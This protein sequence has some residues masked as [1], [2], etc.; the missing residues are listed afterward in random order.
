[1]TP[2]PYPTPLA[3]LQPM[4]NPC[5]VCRHGTGPS[6]ARQC[7]CPAVAGGRRA[8]LAADARLHGGACGPEALHL[9]FPED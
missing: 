8:V 3:W 2:H 4:P 9:T 1:M 5:R 6:H 7:V